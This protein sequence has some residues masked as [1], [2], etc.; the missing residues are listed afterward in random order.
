MK[1]LFAIPPEASAGAEDF[2]RAYAAALASLSPAALNWADGLQQFAEIHATAVLKLE[3]TDLENPLAAAGPALAG[4][5]F[6]T[7]EQVGHARRL[8]AAVADPTVGMLVSWLAL[9]EASGRAM[10]LLTR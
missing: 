5:I 4:Q 9:Q 8:L 10:V 1:C 7:P 6:W 3:E 2:C